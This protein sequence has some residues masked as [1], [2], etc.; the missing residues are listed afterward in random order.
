M[1]HLISH[2]DKFFMDGK[3]MSVTLSRIP[4]HGVTIDPVEHGVDAEIDM[5]LGQVSWPVQLPKGEVIRISY[6]PE[7]VFSEVDHEC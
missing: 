2:T 5:T 7:R 4:S 6:F 1:S 3:I